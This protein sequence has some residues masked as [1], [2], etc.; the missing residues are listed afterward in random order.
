MIF[1]D[2]SNGLAANEVEAIQKAVK[3]KKQLGGSTVGRFWL[4]IGY[5][6]MVVDYDVNFY[7]MVV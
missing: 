4:E 1:I 3:G 6:V 7:L 5:Y 2:A